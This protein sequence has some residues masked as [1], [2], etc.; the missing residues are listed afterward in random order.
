MCRAEMCCGTFSYTDEALMQCR[1]VTCLDHML[2]LWRELN[3]FILLF[4]IELCCKIL[5]TGPLLADVVEVISPDAGFSHVQ[6][7]LEVPSCQDSFQLCT[8]WGQ[9]YNHSLLKFLWS[10]QARLISV[11]D[12][13]KCSTSIMLC[14]F[15]IPKGSTSF[16]KPKMR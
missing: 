16:L 14:F 12:D 6:N 8:L 1:F 7:V 10:V 13:G 4:A 15:L 2:A 11:S 5:K 9:G 3:W